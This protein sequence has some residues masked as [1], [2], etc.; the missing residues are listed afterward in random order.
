MKSVLG[1]EISKNWLKIVSLIGFKSS[2]INLKVENIS[3]LA[4]HQI[5]FLIAKILKE[6][7]HK[8]KSTIVSVPRNLVTL[9]NLHLPSQD[10]EE[11]KQ[12][13]VLHIG[14]IV[15]YPREEI[16]YGWRLCG[17]DEMG[18]SRIILGIIHRD[19]INRQMNILEKANLYVEEFMLSS[20]GVWRWVLNKN[21]SI[22]LNQL[23][24]ILDIDSDFADFI[25]FSKE[26]IL[27]SR[28]ITLKTEDLFK[29]ENTIK[30]LI[31]EMRQSLVIFQNEE[32]NKK[33]IKIFL[34]GAG[35]NIPN[36]DSSIMSELEIEVE[37]IAPSFKA[38]KEKKEILLNL[39]LSSLMDITYEKKDIENKRFSFVVP[40]LEIKRQLR[41]RTKELI[42][43]GSLIIYFFTV[44]CGIFLARIYN[45]RKYLKRL[46]QKISMIEP[47][48]KNLEEKWR[49]VEFVK[50]YLEKRKFPFFIVYK[51][52]EIIPDEAAISFI[53]LDK[54]DKVTVKGKALELSDVFKFVNILKN[55]KY[56]KDVRTKSTKRIK[57]K[58]I[59]EFEITF[60][61]E[62]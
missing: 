57:G 4:D 8:T 27:F 37:C 33:P 62:F 21:P 14:R 36:L 24:M 54:E 23:Y 13:V 28:N 52:E 38:Q 55:V 41:Q 44:F 18:Y 22:D 5:S 50:S 34:T 19:I 31:G 59:T 7:K 12:M 30:K 15:P 43:L 45:Q 10:R 9:R 32:V 11:I 3:S 51:L 25:I 17:E 53:N 60:K 49:K 39:S 56:F 20:Y 42:L 35:P 40:E 47:E 48:I 58:D 61:L 6:W 2:L 26:E 16:I 46:N 29:D 1:I